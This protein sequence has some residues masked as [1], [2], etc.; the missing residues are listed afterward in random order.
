MGQGEKLRKNTQKHVCHLFPP[1]SKWEAPHPRLFHH[2][3]LGMPPPRETAVP[4]DLP[5][6]YWEMVRVPSPGRLARFPVCGGGR[7]GTVHVG[8]PAVGCNSHLRPA[9]AVGGHG[10][11]VLN[12]AP[13]VLWDV[14]RGQRVLRPVPVRRPLPPEPRRGRRGRSRQ[15][16][17]RWPFPQPLHTLT[18]PRITFMIFAPFCPPPSFGQL[19]GTPRSAGP[20]NSLSPNSCQKMPFSATFWERICQKCKMQRKIRRKEIFDL[21]AGD[22]SPQSSDFFFNLLPDRWEPLPAV[23]HRG[24]RSGKQQM[25]HDQQWIW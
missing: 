2:A 13:W 12:A 23:G 19:F 1:F 6:P 20:K 22:L 11:P 9:G 15:E 10:Q 25:S 4:Q 7:E 18:R 8:V 17:I 5:K 3:T 16:I 24:H 14:R 21:L